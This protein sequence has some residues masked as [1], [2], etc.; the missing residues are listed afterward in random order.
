[1][2]DNHFATGI[3]FLWALAN[4][5]GEQALHRMAHAFSPTSS[6][7]RDMILRGIA[8]SRGDL[9]AVTARTTLARPKGFLNLLIFNSIFWSALFP[10][11]N[12]MGFW[13]LAH[14]HFRRYSL[15]K[16]HAPT[17]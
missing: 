12:A 9:I 8:T 2:V 10:R 4:G 11:N 1:L 5:N 16:N 13:F 7:G 14:E 17:G 15:I 6:Q 3:T